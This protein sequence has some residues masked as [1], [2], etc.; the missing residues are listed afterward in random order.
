MGIVG[1]ENV[2]DADAPAAPH[3]ARHFAD[4]ARRIG[5]MVQAVAGDGD[6]ERAIGERQRLRVAN[7]ELQ[8]CE[9]FRCGRAPRAIENRRREVSPQ[10]QRTWRA[11]RSASVPGPQARSTARSRRSAFTMRARVGLS[12]AAGDGVVAED[13]R[14]ARE[15]LA[16]KIFLL[17]WLSIFGWRSISLDPI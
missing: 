17:S 3:H 6:I 16:D 2:E 12:H 15:M 1:H 9:A 11:N 14:V 7:R 10:I 4:R 13:L 5:K 8:I